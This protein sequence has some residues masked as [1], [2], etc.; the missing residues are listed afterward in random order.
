MKPISFSV[1]NTLVFLCFIGTILKMFFPNISL[2][3]INDYFFSQWNYLIWFFQFFSSQFLHGD[4]LHFFSNAIFIVYFWN[5]LEAYI[6]KKS[7]L[8]FFLLSSVFIWIFVTFFASGTTIGISWFALAL[9]TFYTLLL[10]K[11]HNPEYTGGIT[12]IAVNI[13]MGML[14]WISLLGHLSGAIFGG[15]F[16]FLYFWIQ[17][18]KKSYGE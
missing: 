14:P 3:G 15:F 7:M 6:W 17:K 9:L 10:K 8:I 11:Q 5:I 2:F 1:S 18:T 13:F 16:F 12:A 4:L